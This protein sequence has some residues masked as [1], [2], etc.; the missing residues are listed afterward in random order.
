MVKMG[1]NSYS[2]LYF[3]SSVIF[4]SYFVLGIT[5]AVI[6]VKFTETQSKI[7]FHSKN[8]KK[9]RE[10]KKL[11]IMYKEFKNCK[12]FYNKNQSILNESQSLNFNSSLSSFSIKSPSFN[13]KNQMLYQ[14]NLKNIYNICKKNKIDLED[15]EVNERSEISIPYVLNSKRNL[16]NNENNSELL[17]KRNKSKYSST[18]D[19]KKINESNECLINE[20]D[21]FKIMENIY[22]WPESIINYPLKHSIDGSSI[23]EEEEDEEEGEVEEERQRKDKED[24]IY[25]KFLTQISNF[26][27][28]KKNNNIQKLN[29]DY[30]DNLIELEKNKI[31]KKLDRNLIKIKVDHAINPENS[32]LKDVVSDL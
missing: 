30:N 2:Y 10:K 18:T 29:D 12:F 11:K 23:E 16:K 15:V 20:N 28:H 32:S 7:Y 17:T 1:F 31:L 3:F 5:L 26:P 24:T 21:S 9:I 22:K 25:N 8:G 14:N 6:K 19:S 27:S 4:G 13:N